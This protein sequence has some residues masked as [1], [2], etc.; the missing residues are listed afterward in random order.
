MSEE[1]LIPHIKNA[2]LPDHAFATTTNETVNLSALAGTT[3]L[4][5]Y[6]RTSPPEGKPIKGWDTIPGARGCAPQNCGFRDH[7]AELKEAGADQVFGLSTQSAAYQ[8]EMAHRLHLPFPI[9]SDEHLILKADL[10]LPTFEAAKMEL[11]KRI[12]LILRNAKI[13]KVFF[14]IEE[15]ARLVV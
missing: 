2:L 9:I 14:P 13:A 11:Y 10:M 12:T 1:R 15:P 7:F 8:A 3:I 5:I 6:P 4:Y